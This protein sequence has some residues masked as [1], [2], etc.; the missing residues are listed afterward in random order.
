MK[1]SRI[2]YLI[3]IESHDV[4]HGRHV[5]HFSLVASEYLGPGSELVR[6][7]CAVLLHKPGVP[8]HVVHLLKE[9]NIVRRPITYKY[10]NILQ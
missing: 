1:Q 8:A 3:T 9:R 2:L 4:F 6:V 5:N 7:V 10:H